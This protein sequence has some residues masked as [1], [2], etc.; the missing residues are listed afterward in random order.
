MAVRII[1]NLTNQQYTLKDIGD[2]VVPANG[3]IDVGG[4]ESKL[5]SLATSNDLISLLSQN[6]DRIY[7]SD[8]TRDYGYIEGLDLVMR[9]EYP[10]RPTETDH[11]GRWIVKSDS[12]RKDYDVV[13]QGCGDDIYHSVIGGGTDFLFDFSNNSCGTFVTAPEGYLRKQVKWNFMDL[14]YMR[15][16]TLFYVNMPTG[17]YI[18]FYL[19]SP[20]GYPYSVKKI[21]SSGNIVRETRLATTETRWMHWIIKHWCDGSQQTS[22]MSE[23]AVD[24]PSYPFMIFTAEIT[25][26][27]AEGANQARGNWILNFYRNRTVVF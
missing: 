18:D 27:N 2:I 9:I 6:K 10:S 16:G 17:S 8:G 1:K 20:A 25:I 24:L 19:S 7:M 4:D 15:G 5:I 11:Q 21:D 23:T 14:V 26:P 3:A 12:R 13:F 22:I